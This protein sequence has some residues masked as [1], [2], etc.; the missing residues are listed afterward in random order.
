MGLEQNTGRNEFNHSREELRRFAHNL[1]TKHLQ[2]SHFGLFFETEDFIR[3]IER[4]I[5]SNCMSYR[6]GVDALQFEIKH[7]AEQDFLITSGQAQLYLII[8][9]EKQHKLQQVVLKQIGF[10]SGGA[11]VFS[12]A[13][14]CVGSLGSACAGFGTPMMIQ[15]VNNVY[16]N[17][18]YLLLRKDVSGPVRDA[19]RYTA[20]TLGYSNDVADNGIRCGRFGFNR[21][22]CCTSDFVTTI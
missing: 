9:K 16:E 11:Q 18:Y 3:T 22:R 19:Y 5:N 12:G 13:G 20:Q 7:L 10:I 15:G 4:E 8:K 17:G 21:I 2:F 6:G 1:S 14:V